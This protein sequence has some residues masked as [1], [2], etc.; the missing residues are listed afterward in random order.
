MMQRAVDGHF[1]LVVDE[2]LGQHVEGA[3]A[4]GLDGGFDGAIAG[5]QDHG[6]IRAVLATVGQDVEAVT[7][8]QAQV[9]QGQ[10]V[11][12]LGHGGRGFGDA[13]DGVDGKA[14]FA[15]PGGHGLE[16]GTIVVHQQQ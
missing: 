13:G 1:Q 7:I 4:N 15:Q 3:G 16:Q 14:E 5:H 9:D 6:R 11:I 10:V 12:L 8:A 2:R